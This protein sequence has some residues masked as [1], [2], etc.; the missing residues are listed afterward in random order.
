MGWNI[1]TKEVKGQTKYKIWS[2]IT[3]SY[4]TPKWLTK[5]EVIKFLFWA[6]FREFMNLF[7]K[8]SMEFP[9]GWRGK[10][11]SLY[12]IPNERRDAFYEFQKKAI[13]DDD[14][15]FGKVSEELKKYGISISIDDNTYNFTT[16]K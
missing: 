7:I 14:V 4:I 10:D 11:G 16:K 8:D 3:D 6:R 5:D 12:L 2:T 13:Q 9:H 15:F 1:T